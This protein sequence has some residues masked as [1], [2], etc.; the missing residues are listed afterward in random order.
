MNIKTAYY[1]LWIVEDNG[2]YWLQDESGCDE[3]FGHVMPT[4]ADVVAYIDRVFNS[5]TE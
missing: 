1:G 5:I 2:E 3:Y 4:E